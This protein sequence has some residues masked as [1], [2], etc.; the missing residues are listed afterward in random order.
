MNFKKICIFDFE[1]DGKKPEEC[2]PVQ[3]A[4]TIIDARKLNRVRG[5]KFITYMRPPGI[6]DRDTY[7]TDDIQETVNWHAKN[8]GCTSDDILEKWSEAP[9]Q[10]HAWMDFVQ[11]LDRFNP[12][13]TMYTAPIPAGANIRNFDLIICD[14]LNKLHNNSKSIFYARDRIDVIDLAF[15]WFESMEEPKSYSMDALR[16]F[17]GISKEGGHDAFKDVDDCEQIIR[18]FLKLHRKTAEKVEFR[19]SMKPQEVEV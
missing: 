11:F 2:N 3:L 10:K 5:G 14:R 1:T 16:D 17:L 18:R 4:A 15:Y 19:D 12:R 9:T 8:Y 6:E 13:K 7:L